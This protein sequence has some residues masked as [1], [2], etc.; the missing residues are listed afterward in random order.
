[1]L[2]LS[3]LYGFAMSTI[4]SMKTSVLL[5]EKYQLIIARLPVNA[6]GTWI[7]WRVGLNPYFLSS[8]ETYYRHV[9][10]IQQITGIN[11]NSEKP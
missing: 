1:M 4:L 7:T 2:K 10:I 11:I 8:R 6:R 9:K 3:H 5:D